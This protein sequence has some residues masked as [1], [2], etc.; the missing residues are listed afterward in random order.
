MP[1]DVNLALPAPAVAAVP[2]CAHPEI[3]WVH[4]TLYDALV[5][6]DCRTV[7][8]EGW[9]DHHPAISQWLTDGGA[10]AE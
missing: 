10:V 3:K 4:G 8:E 1:A 9:P 6:G 5:C 2:G 7:L